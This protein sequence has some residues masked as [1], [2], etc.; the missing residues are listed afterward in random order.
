MLGNK[1]KQKLV[2]AVRRGNSHDVETMVTLAVEEA[3]YRGR[4]SV[5]E[6]PPMQA[7]GPTL[8]ALCAKHTAEVSDA[9]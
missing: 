2:D 7:T 8:Q 3:W 5:Q 6:L 1:Y 9:C 4:L